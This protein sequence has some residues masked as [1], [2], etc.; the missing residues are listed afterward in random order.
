MSARLCRS[1]VIPWSSVFQGLL[2]AELS[3][4]R[5]ISP[6]V[7]LF[8]NRERERET[9]IT[10]AITTHTTNYRET[11]WH[12]G[13]HTRTQKYSHMRR[14]CLCMYVEDRWAEK[15]KYWWVENAHVRSFMHLWL[16]RSESF[17]LTCLYVCRVVCADIRTCINTFL[18]TYMYIYIH[19][20]IHT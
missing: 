8:F 7:M 20:Y 3:M 10:E 11:H 1:H 9:A 13:A 15:T 4:H 14:A 12:V 5:C 19:N 18:R 2:G 6:S 17:R 16:C